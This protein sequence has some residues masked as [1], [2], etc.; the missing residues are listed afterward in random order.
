MNGITVVKKTPG[1]SLTYSA[2]GR[3]SERMAIYKPGSRPLLDTKSVSTFI[4][5][6]PAFRTVRNKF[7]LF[8]SHPVYDILLEQ[9]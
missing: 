1:S 3:H 5:E 7:M 2:I 9:P 6:L 8:I 4:L